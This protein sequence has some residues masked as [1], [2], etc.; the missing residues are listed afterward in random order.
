MSLGAH[1]GIQPMDT[2][3]GNFLT[4]H[5]RLPHVLENLTSTCKNIWASHKAAPELTK[6]SECELYPDTDWVFHALC[7]SWGAAPKAA[8]THLHA[9]GTWGDSRQSSFTLLLEGIPSQPEPSSEA[10]YNTGTKPDTNTS[11]ATPQP[12]LSDFSLVHFS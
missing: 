1:S 5:S 12:A 6:V 9:E 10:T 3:I 4:L 2:G 7:V 8:Q 11:L